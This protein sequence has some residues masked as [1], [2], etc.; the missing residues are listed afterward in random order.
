MTELSTQYFILV[1]IWLHFVGDFL[2]QNDKIAKLKSS[3][4]KWLAIHSYL[5]AVPFLFFGLKIAAV[6]GSM[7]GVVDFA[8]SKLTKK[9]AQNESKRMFFTV[10]GFDQALHLSMLIGLFA[11]IEKYI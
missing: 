2:L 9:Y 11:I 4:L 5:Y 7:H 6:I 1:L 8:T 10:I 3:S